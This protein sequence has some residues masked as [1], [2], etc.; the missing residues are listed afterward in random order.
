MLRFHSNN[1]SKSVGQ[2]L[3]LVAIFASVTANAGEPRGKNWHQSWK[4]AWQAS[5]TQGRPILMFITMDGC[6]YCEK[7]RHETYANSQVVADLEHNFVLV[8]IDSTRYPKAMRKLNIHKFPT[9]MIVGRDARV[10]DS[11]SGYA[12][13]EQ[14]R[15][16]LR[17]SGSTLARR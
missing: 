16:W 14:L 12:G 13:P 5:Q 8:S 10:I 4:S 1:V 17:S 15:S 11:M 3:L 6:Y 7:M 2:L 9:T